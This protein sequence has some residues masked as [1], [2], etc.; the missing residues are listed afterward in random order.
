MT[1]LPIA[2]KNM[3]QLLKVS[4]EEEGKKS[5]ESGPQ[6]PQACWQAKTSS[7]VELAAVH[8]QLP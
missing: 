6:R 7:H 2:A 1:N 8:G 3:V 4:S 5:L